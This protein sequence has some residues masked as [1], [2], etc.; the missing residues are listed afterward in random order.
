ML[1]ALKHLDRPRGNPECLGLIA[2]ELFPAPIPALPLLQ[3]HICSPL[4][5]DPLLIEEL[6][7]IWEL[8][9]QVLFPMLQYLTNFMFWGPTILQRG[10]KGLF[11]IDIIRLP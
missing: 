2:A 3:T 5:R 10:E 11:N 4:H 9:V 7:N 8:A 1:R 6:K